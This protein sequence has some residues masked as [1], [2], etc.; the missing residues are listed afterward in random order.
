LTLLWPA[1]DARAT[2]LLRRAREGDREA[3]RAAYRELYPRVAA[4]VGRRC[5]KRED[6]EDL[7][8]R[9]FHRL[10]ERL[11]SFD[12]KRGEAVAFALSIARSLL[13]DDARATRPSVD[14]SEVSE[15]ASGLI[16]QR[17]P[18]HAVLEGEELRELRARLDQLP[19]ATRELLA[20]RYGDGLSHRQIAALLG[21]S[22][23]AVKQRASR[24]LREL[25]EGLLEPARRGALA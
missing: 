24:A 11:P 15:A 4:F 7:I 16:E 18:L 5:E 9:T 23:E 22:E 10:L 12:P 2:R 19:A 14:L 6:R 25:R 17:T 13:L 1:P 20:L 8:A 21:L 3:F